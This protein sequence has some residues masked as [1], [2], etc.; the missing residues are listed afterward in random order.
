MRAALAAVALVALALAGAPARAETTACTTVASLPATLVVPGHYCLDADLSVTG[1][2]FN[3]IS[4]TAGDVVLDCNDHRISANTADNTAAGVY[5]SDVVNR[6]VVRNCRIEGFFYGIA[7]AYHETPEPRGMHIVGNRITGSLSGLFLYGSGNLV[8]NNTITAGQRFNA[9]YPTGIYLVGGYPGDYASDN[10]V[11]GNVVQDFHPSTPSDTS[12]NLSIGIS[13]NYQR[14]AVIE[15]N[16][17]VGLR[18]RTGG[19]TFGIV[20]AN[21]GE[22]LVR[23]NRVLSP[24]IGAAPL[25][26]GNWAGIFLQGTAEELASNHCAGNLVGHFNNNYNGCSSTGNTGF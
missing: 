1:G 11:R 17:I 12:Y 24:P 9:G 22:T 3:G 10:V 15:D 20:T 13:L 25:D 16:T 5:M 19:G 18:A 6:T 23:G 7:S 26:G 4:I 8:E 21:T 2:A 14:G